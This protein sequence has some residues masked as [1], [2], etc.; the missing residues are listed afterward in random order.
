[1]FE[2]EVIGAHRR[3]TPSMSVVILRVTASRARRQLSTARAWLRCRRPL[4]LRAMPP[5]TLALRNCAHCPLPAQQPALFRVGLLW[6][7]MHCCSMCSTGALLLPS[8]K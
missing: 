3:C 4:P 1:M 6:G 8:S 2:Q 7:E 5:G